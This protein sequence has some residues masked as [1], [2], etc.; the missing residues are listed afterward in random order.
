MKNFWPQRSTPEG[1]SIEELA[2]N[3]RKKLAN[4]PSEQARK[5]FIQK[6]KPFK[7]SSSRQIQKFTDQSINLDQYKKQHWA[8]R[9]FDEY[10]NA[11]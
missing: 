5:A 8:N 11:A 1:F 2:K 10:R 3:A 4:A 9:Q 7:V 6:S